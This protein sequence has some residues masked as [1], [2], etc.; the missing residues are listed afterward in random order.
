MTPPAIVLSIANL[1]HLDFEMTDEALILVGDMPT[2]I[3]IVRGGRDKF[4]DP[5]IED[6][7]LDRIYQLGKQ[8]YGRFR[9]VTLPITYEGFRYKSDFAKAF[10]AVPSETTEQIDPQKVEDQSELHEL[11]QRI[12]TYERAERMV[13]YY[14]A[15][16]A[17]TNEECLYVDCLV[18]DFRSNAKHIVFPT[19]SL[20]KKWMTHHS[21]YVRHE[22]K[23]VYLPMTSEI[24]QQQLRKLLVDE[25]KLS[26]TA[27]IV[28]V[29][30]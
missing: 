22:A 19:T 24:E 28:F 2:G 26:K 15:L 10:I 13:A 9:H 18:C 7:I 21:Y 25:K 1:T 8:L 6:L 12:H 17:S 11:R 20:F 16:S 5:P 3:R 14:D 30:V 4:R 23:F 29:D 27:K